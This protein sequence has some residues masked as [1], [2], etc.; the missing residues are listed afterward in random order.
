GVDAIPYDKFFATVGLRLQRQMITAADA[1]FRSA[2]HMGRPAT[3]MFVSAGSEAEKAGL[4]AGDTIQEI[5]GRASELQPETEI[6]SMRVGDA[7]NLRVAR[8]GGQRHIKFRIGA[9]PVENFVVIER[10]DATA[11]QRARRAAWIRGDSE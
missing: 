6:S 1:G 8:D 2:R 10:E 7:V 5:N 11:A 3:V 9:R 4:R